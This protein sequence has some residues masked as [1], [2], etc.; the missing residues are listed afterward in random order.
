MSERTET[1]LGKARSEFEAVIGS[2]IFDR[3]PNLGI[4]MRYVCGKFF[5]G[6]ADEIKEYNIAVEAFGR[7]A[8]FDKR[9]DSIVR[10][11]AH[12]LRK[13]LQQYYEQEDGAG[14]ALRIEIPSGSYVPA[15]VANAK[16]EAAVES[17][18]APRAVVEAVVPVAVPALPPVRPASKPRWK[19]MWLGV[20]AAV[21]ALIAIAVYFPRRGEARA[22]RALAVARGTGAALLHPA[23]AAGDA[24]RI[25]AGSTVRSYTDAS[26]AV[27]EGDR[28][29]A[30]GTAHT[31]P[32]R[33]IARTKDPT[34]FLKSREGDFQYD[35]PLKPGVYEM[36][37]F[38]AETT[39][40][41]GNVDGG[42]ETSRLQTVMVNGRPVMEYFDIISDASGANTADVKVFKDV[43]PA[44][45]GALHVRFVSLKA[46]AFVNAVEIVPG[47]RG[48]LRPIRMV[49]RDGGYTDTLG[50]IWLPDTYA[51]GGR[52]VV[53]QQEVG[54]TQDP[55]LYHSERY[56]NFSYAIPVA[57][58]SYTVALYFA[59]G[60]H[61]PGRPDGGGVGSRLFDVYCNR[62]PLVRDLD[63]FAEAKGGY[64][65][66]ERKFTGLR[67]NAQGKLELAFVPTKNY[68]CVN[69]VEVLDEGR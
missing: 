26:G 58:G 15:F 22:A 24:I 21:L 6:K 66:L 40:G 29:F 45:D 47:E 20:T 1:D 65:A 23:A 28:F 67:P 48:R 50:R 53:R 43:E 27:W 35:I 39:Y 54:G 30:G 38:F 8:D 34:I 4:L 51:A 57:P 14:H 19:L 12:R 33:A 10:V 16:V 5:E 64:R 37:L 13:R 2:P 60:W 7:P 25:M 69:A 55:G 31:V 42:G 62:T 9:R 18:P 17:W 3:A 49:A 68:A 36:R 41:E 56:G 63:I 32:F 11:E 52:V 44:A 59:E 46:F 61:G